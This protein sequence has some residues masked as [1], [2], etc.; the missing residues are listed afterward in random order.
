MREVIPLVELLKDLK[1]IWNIIDTLSKV[2]YKVFEGNKSYIAVA[3]KIKHITIKY[4]H[5]RSLVNKKVIQ[6][7]YIDTNEQLA[8]ILTKP[9]ENSQFNKLL[10]ALIG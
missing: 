8:D 2:F 3:A 5:F 6:I 7:N 9:V 4:H 10:Y 1:R